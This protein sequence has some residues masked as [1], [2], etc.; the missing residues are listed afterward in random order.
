[1]RLVQS[2]SGCTEMAL[3]EQ[4]ITFAFGMGLD[5]KSDPLQI[6]AGKFLSLSN[7]VFDELSLL[8]KRNGFGS[9][10]STLGSVSF[11]TTFQG[12]LIGLG[13]NIQAYS[14]S[15]NQFIS[16]G[17]FPQV[18]LSVLPISNSFYSQSQ[19]DMAISPNGLGCEVTT[20]SFGAGNTISYTYTILDYTTGQ[21]INGPNILPSPASTVP[22]TGLGPR[23]FTVGSQFIVL[24]AT[25][26]VANGLNS[27]NYISVPVSSPSIVSGPVVISSNC[28]FFSNQ[29]FDGVVASQS[30]LFMAWYSQ[31]STITKGA[32]LGPGL[33]LSPLFTL[34]TSSFSRYISVAADTTGVGNSVWTASTG[35]SIANLSQIT[36]A[37]YN[38][39]GQQILGGVLTNSSGSIIVN[40]NNVINPLNVTMTAQNGVM[41]SFVEVQNVYSYDFSVPTNLVYK[42]SFNTAGVLGSMSQV[43]R[44][45]GLGSKAFIYNSTSFF[46]GTFQ[47]PFQ[48]TYFLLNS[49]GLVQAKV[50]Y[51]NGGGYVLYNGLPNASVIGSSCYIPYLNQ[52]GIAPPVKVTN[53]GTQSAASATTGVNLGKFNFGI[54]NLVTKEIGNNLL[55]NGGFLGAYDGQQ[56]NE[57]NF[58]LFPDSVEVQNQTIGGAITQQ[59]YWYQS[60][61]QWQ[62]NRGN[63]FYSAPS[64]PVAIT[65]GTGSS[66]NTVN[67]P[68]PR[69]TYKNNIA[70][71]PIQVSLFRYSTATPLYYNIA[72]F[73]V[74]SSSQY[75]DS[76]T[77]IDGRG[78]AQ[79][80]GGQIIYTNNGAIVEDT[81]GP[82]C[83]A[84]TTFDSRFWL[85]DAEDQNLLWFSKQVIENTT[86][87]MSDLFTFYVA[88]NIGAEGPTGNMRCLAPMDDKLI[89]FKASAA[90]YINGIGP[91]N[92]GNNNQYSEPIFIAGSVGCVYPN[93]IVLIPQGLMFQSSKG[94]WLLGR[95]LSTQYIGKD[96]ETLILGNVVLSA[97][98]VPQTNQVRFT[99]NTG[100]VLLY[101][102]FVNQWGTFNGIPGISS[103]LYQNLHTYVNSSSS[104]FQETPGIYLDGT[105]PTLMSFTTGW[106]SLAGLQGYQRA[107]RAYLLGTYYT[108]HNFTM[109]V[110]Y[111][112]NPSILQTITVN[113]TNTVGSG[114][115]VEQWQLNFQKQSCQSFQLTFNEVSS[116]SAG[117]GLTMSGVELVFGVK[118]QFPRNL[119]A[120]N[121]T[122]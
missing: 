30:T 21:I 34:S 55:I 84:F 122:S 13:T 90:Y 61:Y 104:L 58:F 101:D 57:N 29:S 4:T 116:Q 47:S 67:V 72:S 41:T 86:V 27:L 11:L 20:Q 26:I 10:V 85:I 18:Q 3:Q 28:C 22:V 68:L 108:P 113:P 66:V 102:Y 118:K 2:A 94:I 43:A 54:S 6:P 107:Y 76:T 46:L 106:L 49:T 93:S 63:I 88:P 50:N 71:S 45:V 112:Y 32:T 89:I 16:K 23:V 100:V 44:G 96:I 15:I 38:L 24:Y 9:L 56:F 69:L 51:S 105:N 95:D 79:I 7:S 52:Y 12:N 60:I 77:F 17:S 62:D 75:L 8:K 42:Q 36:Y 87:E 114:S 59:N 99:M 31:N 103:T 92:G 33:T 97:L 64:V 111:D 70:Q 37:N 5:L 82:A 121:K 35:T 19:V 65:N 109:G 73:I 53:T 81:N 48:S 74:N 78:D 110:G 40:T 80:I 115:Q 119:G 14:Q 25:S 117:Q 39:L 83:T 120:G 91:D 98:T 1:M